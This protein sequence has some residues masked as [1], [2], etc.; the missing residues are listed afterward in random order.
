MTYSES[1][2]EWFCSDCYEEDE[3]DI[4]IQSYHSGHKGGLQFFELPHE[5]AQ[6][7]QLYYGV[8]LEVENRY[9]IMALRT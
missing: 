4:V 1:R 2:Q 5:R 3:E 7:Q 9:R 8:E 6:N